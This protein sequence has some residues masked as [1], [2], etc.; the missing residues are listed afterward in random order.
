MALPTGL[1]GNVSIAFSTESSKKFLGS[2]M[3]DRLSRSPLTLL[4]ISTDNDRDLV[5]ASSTGTTMSKA[6]PDGAR[7]TK[8]ELR[9]IN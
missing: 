4:S 2:R 8:I 7:R 5:Q 9:G 6:L 1:A 3:T